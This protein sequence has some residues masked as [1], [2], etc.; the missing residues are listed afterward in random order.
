MGVQQQQ[1]VV[2]VVVALVVVGV[3]VD[4]AMKNFVDDV[5]RIHW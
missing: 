1:Q 3:M 4:E 2:Q 5:I